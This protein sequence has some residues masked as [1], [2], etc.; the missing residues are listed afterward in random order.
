LCEQFARE[1]FVQVGVPCP[2]ATPALVRLNGRNLG[3]CVLIEGANKQFVRRNFDSDQGNLYDGGSGGDVTRAL[4]ALSGGK[5]DDRS[6]L[7]NLA[8]AAREPDPAKRFAQLTTVLDL[9]RFLSFAATEAFI[10]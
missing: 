5:P 6:D 3:V 9:E 4:N 8:R 7:T 10:G 1:L 2:R